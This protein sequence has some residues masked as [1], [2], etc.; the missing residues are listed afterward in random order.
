[1]CPL[2]VKQFIFLKWAPAKATCESQ[3]RDIWITSKRFYYFYQWVS[4]H[5]G[6]NTQNVHNGY[7]S[8]FS[9]ANLCDSGSLSSLE[10]VPPF[11][12]NEPTN[13]TAQHFL[14]VKGR[15]RPVI[16]EFECLLNPKCPLCIKDVI[17][18]YCMWPELEHGN[19]PCCE[20]KVNP[21]ASILGG[22]HVIV[23]S[24]I[25]KEQGQKLDG[26]FQGFVYRNII[27]P[28]CLQ[29]SKH[30]FQISLEDSLDWLK[31]DITCHSQGTYKLTHT[32][33][34]DANTN[35]N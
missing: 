18:K 2:I 21:L 29:R 13:K 23:G 20:N 8:Y 10:T 28:F 25:L 11:L 22:S 30:W 17:R 6:Y 32:R 7:W 5:Q 12:K 9:S 34:Y 14:Y 16:T 1:M 15:N 3:S 19:V 4:K 26:R 35:K 31:W 27:L 33:V 24:W